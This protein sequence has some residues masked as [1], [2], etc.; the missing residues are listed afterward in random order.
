M[1]IG[2]TGRIA[3]GK[4]TAAAILERMGFFR[5]D[6]DSIFHELR[7]T[8]ED[9]NSKILNRFKS[10]DNKEIIKVLKYEDSALADL[11]SITHKYVVEEIMKRIEDIDT[12]NIVLDVPVPV[13]VGFKDLADII[14]V[15]TCSPDVQLKRILERDGC[16]IEEA[17]SKITMQE[18]AEFYSNLGDMV[19]NT[20]NLTKLELEKILRKTY[21]TN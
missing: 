11:N 19:I 15:T 21:N 20:D 2:I 16:S 5:I 9:M 10:L 8:S 3:S 1:I 14:I 7:A 4:S 17:L 6:A 13:D 18:S 12:D